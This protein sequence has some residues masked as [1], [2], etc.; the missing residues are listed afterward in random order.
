M[1]SKTHIIIIDDL[2]PNN[3]PVVTKLKELFETVVV[4]DSPKAGIEY[5][6]KNL[7]EKSIVVLDYKFDNE[8]DGAFVLE[9][10]RKDSKLIPVIMWTANGNQIKEFESFV[11]NHAFA[12]VSKGDT[13]G[14]IKRV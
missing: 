7:Q 5:I 9:N 10:I 2:L 14:L 1:K 6:H 12:F 11:N 13:Q 8:P 3:D 4:I